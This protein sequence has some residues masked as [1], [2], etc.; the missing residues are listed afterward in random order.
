MQATEAGESC[1]LS[2]GNRNPVY[3]QINDRKLETLSSRLLQG[4]KPDIVLPPKGNNSEVKHL[5]STLVRSSCDV[6]LEMTLEI[7]L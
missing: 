7:V 6:T 2:R 3:L 4:Q 1:P 5:I